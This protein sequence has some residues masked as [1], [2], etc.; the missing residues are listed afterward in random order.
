MIQRHQISLPLPQGQHLM[1]KENI[2]HRQ[3]IQKENVIH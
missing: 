1:Q 2:I 3:L